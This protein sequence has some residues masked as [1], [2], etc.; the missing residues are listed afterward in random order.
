MKWLELGVLGICCLCML[1]VVWHWLIA[2]WLSD[3]EEQHTDARLFESPKTSTLERWLQTLGISLA[4]WMFVV[5]VLMI[6]A[7]AFSLMLTAF[8]RHLPVAFIA[9]LGVILLCFYGLADLAAWRLRRLEVALVDALDTMRASLHAGLPAR[10]ALQTAAQSVQQPLKDEL[11]EVLA[12]LDLGYSAERALA[13][14]TNRYNTEGTRLF[15]QV[16]IARHQ[17]GSDLAAML[18]SVAQLM[19]ER[20]RQRMTIAGQLSGTRYAAIFSGLLP[21]AVVPLFL[22]QEPDW[23]HALLNHPM[24]ASYLAGALLMQ[25]LGFLWLRK[26]LRVNA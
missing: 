23:F 20:I 9:S 25:I 24:G 10:Q 1:Y 14:L 3:Q 13:R 16:L 5:G 6:A 11:N 26:I 18:T 12:R 17:T 15:A 19:Q 21:Y 7:L 4:P 22:W 8:P 2:P